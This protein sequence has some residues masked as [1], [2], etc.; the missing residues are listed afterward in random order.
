MLT[1][2]ARRIKKAKMNMSKTKRKPIRLTASLSF[3]H[4]PL[5]RHV[6]TRLAT[7]KPVGPKARNKLNTKREDAIVRSERIP[8]AVRVVQRTWISCDKYWYKT[9]ALLMESTQ[10]PLDIH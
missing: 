8:T 7:S 3:F 5:A 10:Y 9:S 6:K 2:M 4:F 1:R